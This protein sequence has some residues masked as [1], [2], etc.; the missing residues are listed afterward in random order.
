MGNSIGPV[1]DISYSASG[2][3]TN[4]KIVYAHGAGRKQLHRH[5]KITWR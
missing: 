4:I 5:F 2:A 1:H 3:M